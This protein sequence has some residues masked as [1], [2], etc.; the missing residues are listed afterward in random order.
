MFSVDFAQIWWASK[1]FK[2]HVLIVAR[3]RTWFWMLGAEFPWFFSIQSVWIQEPFYWR[4]S[5]NCCPYNYRC[6]AI[7]SHA[8]VFKPVFAYLFSLKPF[9]TWKNEHEYS[10]IQRLIFVVVDQLFKALNFNPSEKQEWNGFCWS[11]ITQTRALWKTSIFF[12][13]V[14]V[15]GNHG[16]VF[17]FF[18]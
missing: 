5:L 9:H 8:I 14:W 15:R 17:V 1:W 18:L 3:R 4:C 6:S 10:I 11:S 7:L 12:M 2:I 16:E 13:C